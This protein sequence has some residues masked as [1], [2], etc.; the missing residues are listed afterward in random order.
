MQVVMPNKTTW[1]A[2]ICRESLMLGFAGNLVN[3]CAVSRQYSKLSY[4]EY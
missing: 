1:Y 4:V 2:W 3:Y